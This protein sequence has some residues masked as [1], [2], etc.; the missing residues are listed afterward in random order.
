MPE[1]RSTVTMRSQVAHAENASSECQDAGHPRSPPPARRRHGSRRADR[2]RLAA[3]GCGCAGCSTEM[4]GHTDGLHA[5]GLPRV[6]ASRRPVEA[7][8]VAA[9]PRRA[10]SGSPAA[11][12][13]MGARRRI[14]AGRRPGA[15]GHRRRLLDGPD[16][17]HQ[18]PVRPV[19]G[20]DRLCHRGRAPARSRGTSPARPPEKLV[21]GSLV[22]TP[23]AGEV[24][25][26]DPLAWWSYVP[27]ASWRHPEGP[28]TTIEGKDEYPVVQVCWDDAAAYARWAGKRLPTEA[29]WEYAREGRQ[30]PD[31]IRLGRRVPARR[32]VAGEHLARPL[33]RAELARRRLQPDGARSAPSRRT[34]SACSTCP[35]TSGSGVPTGIG[36]ATT[37][38]RR[39]TR[40]G[41]PSSYDPDEPGVAKARPA[42]G[43]FPL[44]R[45]VLH[46][47]ISPAPGEEGRSTPARR[48]SASAASR[49]PEGRRREPIGQRTRR[50]DPGDRLDTER[51]RRTGRSG[52]PC[53]LG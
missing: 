4:L 25:L 53:R 20:G 13:W 34:P 31:A 6:A 41:P 5:S 14:D 23:P 42:R 38:A 9:A 50:D 28:E 30:G 11:R 21:P 36:R 37:S 46:A 1:I 52:C 26:D 2:T 19:R 47:D 22:F 48:T 27:G 29:E 8:S 39:G 24:S 49:L 33:P 44:H 12:F 40:R 10:W 32:Q 45:P 7:A 15:R 17:G 16:G 35:A 18:S 3:A 51:S 43:F